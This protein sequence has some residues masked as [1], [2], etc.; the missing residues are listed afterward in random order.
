MANFF[1][2]HGGQILYA[3]IFFAKVLLSE[4]VESFVKLQGGHARHLQFLTWKRILE[5]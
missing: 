3:V 2:G 4:C 1:V 5:F